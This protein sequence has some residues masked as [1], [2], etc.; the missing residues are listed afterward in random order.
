MKL[1]KLTKEQFKEFA[2]SHPLI[3]F[4]QTIE[5]GD[6][7]EKNGW[8]SHFVGMKQKNKLV[9]ATLLLEKSTPIKK[10]IFYS[11]RGFLLDFK[12]KNLLKSFTEAIRLYIKEQ[13]GFFLKIDPYV[14]H[15]ER[16]LYGNIITDGIDN[17]NIIETLKNL[18]Y[19]HL[20]FNL[21]NEGLQP[22][23]MFVLNTDEKIEVIEKNFDSKTKRILRKNHKMCIGTREITKDEIPIF[24]KIMASTSNRREFVDRP[25]SYY[26][27]MWDTFAQNNN[28]KIVV[29]ELKTDQY[30]D[31]LKQE[32]EKLKQD[33]EERENRKKTQKDEI[34]QEKFDAKQKEATEKL[35]KTE[36]K[37]EEMKKLQE[38]HG[39]TVILGGMLFLLYGGEIV[40][41]MGGSFKEHLHFQSAYSIHE[42]MI[43]YAVENK[44]HAYNFYGIT[45]DFRESN[46]LYGIY[47][48]KK[49][50][51]GNVVELI[52]EFDLVI[53]K[54]YYYLY[55]SAFA[56]YH[57]GKNLIN[58]IKK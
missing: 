14:I 34:N 2:D 1:E 11:P 8:I 46:P 13:N 40:Y 56:I 18:G 4:H 39:S 36:E 48:S 7:K 26:Q 47:F 29:A 22:R 24:K 19:K 55:K 51:G 28:L 15:K 43:K 49:G 54:L 50:F 52:G 25:L 37:I 27:N 17:N 38:K 32:Q 53:N 6:L 58:R 23:W 35:I 45:G 3:T 10:S 5:W 57:K 21:M 33:I 16:D 12:D 41:L 31:N 9:A 42:A 30:L 44:F 20:G